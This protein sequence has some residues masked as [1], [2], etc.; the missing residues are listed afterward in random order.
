MLY[1]NRNQTGYPIVTI[2]D[3]VIYE[4]NQ[5]MEKRYMDVYYHQRI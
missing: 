2:S 1:E 5:L 4:Y 3:D